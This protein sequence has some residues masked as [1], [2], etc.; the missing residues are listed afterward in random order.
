[1][2]R[3]H[4]ER[5]HGP[6]QCSWCSLVFEDTKTLKEHCGTKRSCVQ[7]KDFKKEGLNEIEWETITGLVK[8]KYGLKGA[9]Q[10]NHV[11]EQWFKILKLLFP[12]A[13]RPSPCEHLSS[14]KMGYG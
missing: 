1:M 9:D 5:V 11:K 7:Q 6:F 3:E 10:E 2:P 4:L 14:L 12:G 13:R 8:K